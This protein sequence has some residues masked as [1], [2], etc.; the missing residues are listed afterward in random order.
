MRPAPRI[1]NGDWLIV[2]PARPTWWRRALLAVVAVV[3]VVAMVAATAG[4][5]L[6]D[7]VHR[8]AVTPYS[9]A[10]GLTRYWVGGTATWDSTAGTKWATTSG[11]AGGA[12]APDASDF[13]VFD[14]NSGTGITVTLS[15]TSTCATVD[16]TGWAATNT[17]SHPAA[18]AWLISGGWNFGAN[19]WT[20]TKGNATTSSITLGNT[21]QGTAT[22]DLTSNGKTLGNLSLAG[23]GTAHT[24]RLADAL[25]VGAAT[26]TH[27]AGTL[28][29]QN[30]AMTFGSYSHSTNAVKTLTLG[31]SALSMSGATFSL[32]GSGTTITANT[33]TLTATAQTITIQANGNPG[34][35]FGGM[36][37]VYNPSA[38][39]GTRG[40][41]GVGLASWTYNGNGYDEFRLTG[42]VTITGTL[43]LNSATTEQRIFVKSDVAGATRTLTCATLV[44]ANGADW[45]DITLAGA[46]A[47]FD[48]SA[49]EF[50]DAL[51]N[52]GITFPAS[53][54]RYVVGATGALNT[55][56]RYST[57]SGGA[58]GASMPLPQDDV[59]FDA[60]TPGNTY[61]TQPRNWCRNLDLTGFVGTYQSSPFTSAGYSVY[62]NVTL[63]TGGTLTNS[64][65]MTLAG[66]GSHTFTSNGR[67]IPWGL[68]V[69]A[70]GGTYTL[71][72]ALTASGSVSLT[73]TSGTFDSASRAITYPRA[74]VTG[75]NTRS[76]L[77]GTSTVTLT[78]TGT[79]NVWDATVVTNLTLDA[80][81]ATFVI[82]G[83]SANTKIFIGGTGQV[84]GIIDY[85]VAASTGN[86]RWSGSFSVHKIKVNGNTARG[87]Q[88]ATGSFTLTILDT[89]GFQVF[90]TAGNLVTVSS[91]TGGQVHTF[92]FA[93]NVDAAYLSLTDSTA[94]GTGSWWAEN[95]TNGGNN[96]GWVF[97]AR[98]TITDGEP[99][100]DAVTTV[101]AYARDL[102]DSEGL[103]DSSTAQMVMARELTD[104]LGLTDS[105]VLAAVYARELTDAEGL[106]DAMTYV[107][108]VTVL[109]T[110][111][112]AL[113]MTD[114]VAFLKAQVVLLTDA[115]G[116]IDRATW[117][118]TVN[119]AAGCAV[120]PPT[121][122]VAA[123]ETPTTR[124]CPT[125]T[126]GPYGNRR[127]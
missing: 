96:S 58:G 126:V 98:R 59:F 106:T 114:S 5:T 51:G 27:S 45:Q 90:G 49:L 94:S 67:T 75:T 83:A 70:F 35:T 32:A 19:A 78:D 38:S 121:S 52:S 100:T 14:S 95:S 118:Q 62:G 34:N 125:P 63:P 107:A 77:L 21:S 69:D 97:G 50:G 89:D 8:V 72:D 117:L 55:T 25:N 105:Q 116:L 16:F 99:I 3:V 10:S 20:Y 79:T 65:A 127:T 87:L 33:A 71:A 24:Y 120:E 109:V 56:A 28:N 102:T 76:V 88:M 42:N 13:A 110:I 47:P 36:A 86:L 41:R 44:A 81:D 53:K 111:T 68:L 124:S 48:G 11:G 57:S 46:A 93:A 29:T 84:Y 7:A 60:N 74:A 40:F 92:V 91:Q 54:N 73:V 82:T 1:V 22:F 30:F 61:N 119:R 101:A 26:I 123:V 17:V 112:D 39:G 66:R 113:G 18:T 103:T 104:A 85:T 15:S 23:S 9:W 64:T 12:S 80:D 31:S 2:R 108:S 6:G 43:T 37:V 115:L 4:A 122:R